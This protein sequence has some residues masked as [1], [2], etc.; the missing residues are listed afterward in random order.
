MPFAEWLSGGC[1]LGSVEV[2][3]KYDDVKQDSLDRFVIHGWHRC[4]TAKHVRAC[5]RQV[6]LVLVEAAGIEVVQS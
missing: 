6:W 1:R 5:R 4:L 3:L 2:L